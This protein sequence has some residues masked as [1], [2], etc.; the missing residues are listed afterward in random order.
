MNKIHHHFATLICTVIISISTNN[1]TAAE[2][3]GIIGNIDPSTGYY[4]AIDNSFNITLPVTG[5]KQYV[6]SAI[7]DTLSARGTTIVIGPLKNAS[8]YWL[9][10]S[11][12]LATNERSI[13]F[14]EASAK[15]FDWYRR[16][17]SHT[18]D[19]KLIELIYQPFKIN[20]R[21]AA[22][23]IYKQASKKNKGPRFHLFYLVDFNN[24]LAFLWADI[25][26]KE[27]DL[28]IEDKIISGNAEQSLKSIA[29]LR[30]LVF[31]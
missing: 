15:T 25:H 10:I 20:G 1:I 28:E 23:I 7:T 27:D 31:D 13:T 22:S 24:K 2:K 6:I 3:H 12:A 21:Q 9:E 16:L 8:T 17:I 14:A 4:T 19:E 11:N 26:L 18:Y 5:T 30:S 29:M